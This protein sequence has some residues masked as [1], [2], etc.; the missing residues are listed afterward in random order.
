MQS[1]PA[2]DNPEIEA[3]A[4]RL[5]E[6]LVTL[7]R[8][9]SL[10]DPVAMA[11]ESLGLTTPQMHAVLWVGYEK[12]LTMGELARRCGV[13]DKTCTGLVDRLEDRGLAVRQRSDQDRRVVKVHLT[14]RGEKVYRELDAELFQRFCDF[15]SLLGEEDRESLFRI[16]ENLLR[17]LS[18]L[19][20]PR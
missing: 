19:S 6:L 17:K 1:I 12:S 3:A 16:F 5:Q 9:Q 15:L 7:G 18:E 2:P 11:I 10:R 20:R 14:R 13:S 4:R 8:M